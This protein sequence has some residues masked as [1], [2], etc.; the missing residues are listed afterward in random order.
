MD[1]RAYMIFLVAMLFLTV[2]VLGACAQ[3]ALPPHATPVTVVPQRDWSDAI[4]YFVLIDRYADG[5]QGSNSRV[6]RLNPGAYHGGDLLGLARQL[7]EIAAL[8]VTA[9]W[10]NP[11]VKQID[12]P[13]WAQGP[14]GSGWEGGFEHWAFHGYWAEDFERI[15]PHFGSEAQLKALV[16]AARARGLKVLLDV[17]YN[18]PGYG[19]RYLTDPATRHWLR[20]SQ[21]D[22]ATDSLTCQVGGLPDFRTEL[23]EV[24]EYLFRAHLG[25]AQRIG[26]DGFRLDTVKHVEHDFWRAHRARSRA[27]LGTSFFLLG[28]VWGGSYEV[29]EPWFSGDELDAGFDFTFRGSCQGYVEGKGRTIAYAAYLKKRHQVRAG[30]HL[31]HYLSS[32]DEPMFLHELG[33]DIQKFKLCAALQMTSLGIPVIYYGEEV[34]RK[35]GAWPTN[36]GDMPWGD[37]AIAPGNGV[38][39]DEKLREYYRQLIALRR[40]HPALSRGAFRELATDGDLLVFA[41]EDQASND[42]VIVAVNRGEAQATATVPPPSRWTEEAVREALSGA[43]AEIDDGRLV[44]KTPPRT[45]QVYV[46]ER[47]ITGAIPWPTFASSM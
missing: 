21:P 43:P 31:A 33:N 20:E 8:G 35:G 5:D 10:I 16:E 11:V 40:A 39:R 27:E 45:A 14:P 18:H 30:Y 17:V 29:L 6:D 44:I 36:R 23:P 22:C 46:V 3:V 34:A 1:K 2:V 37:R 12:S 47:R 19:A 13:V 38:A 42:S 15:E 26:V 9:I 25:L 7:D 41:R 24:R 28:E 4:L 32:H